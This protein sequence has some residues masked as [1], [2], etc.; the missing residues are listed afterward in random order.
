MKYIITERQLRILKEDDPKVSSIAINCNDYV[1]SKSNIDSDINKI[2]EDT[3]SAIDR[4]YNKMIPEL[5][6]KQYQGIIS[7]IFGKI[8]SMVNQMVISGVYADF[9]Y[10]TWDPNTAF[11]RILEMVYGELDKEINK[12]IIRQKAID[13]AI[14]KKN[15]SKIKSDVQRNLHRISE[16]LNR[17]YIQ[18]KI[19]AIN[20]IKRKVKS[21]LASC[22][23][24]RFREGNYPLL[25]WE[26]IYNVF[27]NKVNKVIDN[28]V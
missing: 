3:E 23:T 8:K 18:Q 5:N 17:V 25:D 24:V 4:V 26:K 21:G 22:K 20:R 16:E 14:N 1:V 9:G 6:D 15:V 10:G 27:L 19:F 11:Y 2:A 7:N 13:I 12:N 28:F